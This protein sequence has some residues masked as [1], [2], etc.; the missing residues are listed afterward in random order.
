[1]DYII[2]EKKYFNTYNNVKTN[3]HKNV[4]FSSFEKYNKL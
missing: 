3:L 4:M 2:V 1:M